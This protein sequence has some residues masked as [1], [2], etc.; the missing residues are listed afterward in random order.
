MPREGFPL[1]DDL[2]IPKEL[3]WLAFNARLLQEADDPDVPPLER[4][5][6]LGIYSNNLDEFYRVRVATLRRLARLGRKSR[7]LIRHDPAEVLERVQAEARR[8]A[9]RFN[10]LYGRILEDLATHG[11]HVVDESGLSKAQAEFVTAYFR[12]KVRHRI[13]PILLT[14]TTALRPLQDRSI[15]LAVRLE[16]STGEKPPLDIL[17]EMPTDVLPRFVILPDR[18]QDRCVIYLDDVIRANLHEI[19]AM[20]P[21][22]VRRA[23]MV[24]FSRDADLDL[25]DDIQ[26]SYMAR[27]TRSLKKRGHSS[28]VRFVHDATM[29][30]D[31]LDV[32]LEKLEIP[33]DDSV[34]PGARYH[35]RS[36]LVKFPDL[37]VPG[38][39]YAPIAPIPHPDLPAGRSGF[40]A[41]AERDILLHFP[42]HPYDHVLDVLREAALDARVTSIQIA[43]YRVARHSAVVNALINAL[44][45]GKEVTVV[46]ELQARFDEEANLHWTERLREEGARVFVDVPGLKVHAKACLITRLERR[47]MR[48]Y[49][50]IG[51]GNYNEDTAR[52]YSDL[53]LMTADPDLTDEVAHMFDLIR[54]PYQAS[55]FRHLV[56]SP[57]NAREEFTRRVEREIA[58]GPRG[59]L[60]VKLNNLSDDLM[61]AKLYEASRAGVPVRLLVRGMFSVRPG[62]AGVSEN[63]RAGGLIDRYLEHARIIV[64]GNDGDPE[65]WIGSADWLPRNFEKRIEVMV[66]IREPRLRDLLLALFDLHDADTVKTRVLDADLRNSYREPRKP[67]VRAQEATYRLLRACGKDAT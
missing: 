8:Q 5:K 32:L 16:D 33:R 19:F 3:S 49:A 55:A 29:P 53:T 36:D 10:A 13:N 62:I 37:G 50:M 26:E 42:Y 1:D 11:I 4:L 18:K 7:G 58:L 56:V 52:F 20:F 21:H 64:F 28:T 51:T 12:D 63:I 24:K 40:E 47:R 65:V 27:I 9:D 35:N 61:V 6:F 25:D 43:L 67:R 46:M 15:Y 44:R 54:R 31:L 34:H 57:Y 23:W 45:N 2:F 17:M 14:K 41:M 39:T 48:R 59:R 66:P 22:D 38:L 30:S 60:D